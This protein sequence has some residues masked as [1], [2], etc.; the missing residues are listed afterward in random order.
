M[1]MV[2]HQTLAKNRHGDFN[3]GMVDRLD[4]GMV[5][6]VFVKNLTTIV[7]PINHMVANAANRGSRAAGHM[8]NVDITPGKI[9]NKR[10]CPLVCGF[11]SK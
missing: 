4:K 3:A 2:G 6:A 9:N 1:K 10:A 7:A 11:C 8:L 5:I